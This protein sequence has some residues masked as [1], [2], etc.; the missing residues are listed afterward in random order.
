MQFYFIYFLLFW[1]CETPGGTFLFFSCKGHRPIVD[2]YNEA[3]PRWGKRR[4]ITSRLVTIY[5]L[6]WMSGW[7][8]NDRSADK[9]SS[10]ARV[11]EL[12]AFF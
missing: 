10:I 1:V 7:L 8:G 4:R 11:H 5:A 12:G 9:C 6:F 2:P 3:V